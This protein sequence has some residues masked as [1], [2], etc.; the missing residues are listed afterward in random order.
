[1]AGILRVNSL[2]PTD[3]SFTR[4]PAQ[5]YRRVVQR[6]HQRVKNS[7]GNW[8]PGNEWYPLPGSWVEITPRYSNSKI[9]YCCNCPVGHVWNTHAI[10]HWYLIVNGKEYARFNKSCDHLDTS[11]TTRWEIPSWGAGISSSIGFLTQNYSS[12]S[13]GV[14]FNSKRYQDGGGT[15][16]NMDTFTSVEEIIL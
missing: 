5:L 10:S 11:A 15:Y 3:D 8:N 2:G 16:F 12:G 13:H 1:M 9:V 6:V 14:H 4:T 7:N